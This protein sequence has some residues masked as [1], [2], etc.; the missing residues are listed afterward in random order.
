MTICSKDSYRVHLTTFIILHFRQKL[1]FAP[2]SP[3]LTAQTALT[4]FFGST[5]SQKNQGRWQG[6]NQPL[7]TPDGLSNY[8]CHNPSLLT[9]MKLIYSVTL[10]TLSNFSL[11]SNYSFFQ[12]ALLQYMWSDQFFCPPLKPC[13]EYWGSHFSAS[14]LIVWAPHHAIAR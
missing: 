8:M 1:L 2:T 4:L 14:F 13:F 12:T 6:H 3:A 9:Q 7:I 10:G 5:L 11:I